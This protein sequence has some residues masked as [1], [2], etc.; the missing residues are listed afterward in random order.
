MDYSI[1]EKECDRINKKVEILKEKYID[2]YDSYSKQVVRYEVG[3][4]G[5]LMHRGYYC[6]SLVEDIIV[7]NAKRGRIAKRITSRT[8][9]SLFLDL[10]KRIT[11]LL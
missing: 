9:N 4:G 8:K 3:V 11:C 1:Y 5:E 10:T 6:P 2:L 7:G